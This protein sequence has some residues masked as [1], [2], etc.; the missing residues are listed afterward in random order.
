MPAVRRCGCGGACGAYRRGSRRDR[1]RIPCGRQ[2]TEQSADESRRL[3]PP[4]EPRDSGC[5]RALYLSGG[6]RGLQERRARHAQ[7][8]AV[9][10]GPQQPERR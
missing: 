1:R 4:G 10:D 5:P 9:S 6:A 3:S 8:L 2:R 7:F